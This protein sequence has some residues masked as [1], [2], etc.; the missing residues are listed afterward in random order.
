MQELRN[1]N[2]DLL[3]FDWSSDADSFSHPAQAEE[4]VTERGAIL[5]LLRRA[6][7][8]YQTLES[9]ELTENAAMVKED[10]AIR[11]YRTDQFFS[12]LTNRLTAAIRNE[13][14]EF[15]IRSSAEIIVEEQLTRNGLETRNWLN[16]MFVAHFGDRAVLVGLLHI[17]SR[18]KEFEV[19]PQGLTMALAALVHKD[20]EVK[21]L[22]VRAFE[23]WASPTSVKVLQNVQ[24]GTPWL[25]RYIDEVVEDLS[26]EH[27]IPRAQVYP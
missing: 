8:E 11:G 13:E 2:S 1:S 7:A 16:E 12:H 3:P 10:T 27:G 24:V 18:F 6:A 23:H 21:E 22:G 4:T 20:D 19:H 17:I 15:G 25:Q 26:L 14:F 5:Q 9:S